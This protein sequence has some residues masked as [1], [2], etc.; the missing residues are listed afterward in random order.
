M[1]HN[2]DD[3]AVEVEHDDTYRRN[4]RGDLDSVVHANFDV[5]AYLVRH[6]HGHDHAVAWTMVN[7]E[8][9]DYYSIIVNEA[10]YYYYYYDYYYYG[11]DRKMN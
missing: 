9:I 5:D 1:V 6:D 3:V 10:H 7:D 11:H 2:W 4:V 8:D